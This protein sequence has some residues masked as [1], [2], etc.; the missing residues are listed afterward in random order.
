MSIITVLGK[1][2][3]EAECVLEASL[4]YRARPISKNKQLS[5]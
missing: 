5:K 3:I 4:G 1:L 2:M